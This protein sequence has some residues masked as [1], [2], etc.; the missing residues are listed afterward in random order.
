MSN[1][2]AIALLRNLEDALD[3]Y[4]ELNE[5][6]K[7]AFRMA[8]TALELFGNSEQL[9]SAQPDVPDIN[10][11]DIISRQA[12]LDAVNSLID[13][14]E[15]ILSDIRESRVDDSV[16]GLCEYDGAYMGQSGDWCNECPGF[17]KDDCFRLSD[18]CRK[19]WLESVELPSAQPGW[20]PCSERLPEED[21]EVLISYRY[22]EGEGDTDHVNID[23]TSYGTTCFGGREIHTLKEWRQPFDYFH[24]NY[25]VIAWIPLPTPY[26]EE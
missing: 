8:I 1:Q 13:R 25:E 15:R 16:C 9:P 10:D 5:E 3:S 11:G 2:E 26:R 21:T 14:F 7:T 23:I 22:K 6:G 4:C 17:E 12:A 24:A 19:R 20:I 18:E